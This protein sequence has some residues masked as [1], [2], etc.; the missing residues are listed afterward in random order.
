MPDSALRLRLRA[1][2]AKSLR[3]LIS[4]WLLVLLV[5]ARAYAA[6]PPPRPFLASHT[7]PFSLRGGLS[8]PGAVHLKQALVGAEFVLIGE[9][10][11]DH[12]TSLFSEA[13]YDACT[14]A[15]VSTIWW[16][17]RIL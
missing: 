4:P 10:H 12:D 5:G 17:S 13:L 3:A 8:G 15:S 16:S 14:R 11:H 6:D 1:G 9:G 7:F 2:Q